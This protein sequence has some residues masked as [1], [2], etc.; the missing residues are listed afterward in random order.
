VLERFFWIECDFLL[1]CGHIEHIMDFDTSLVIVLSIAGAIALITVL[2][3]LFY[4][5]GKNLKVDASFISTKN[6]GPPE[7]IE[8]HIANVGSK[9]VKMA[10]P[11]VMFYNAQH[12]ILYEIKRDYTS[13]R[14]PKILEVGNEMRCKFDCG[15]FHSVLE[16]LSFKPQHIKIVIRDTMGMRFKSNP[17]DYQL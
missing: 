5:P 16:T 7:G 13:C 2:V 15:H 9:R 14:F 12:S 11:F 17:L 1:N 4:K 6:E 8:F 10:T 3:A